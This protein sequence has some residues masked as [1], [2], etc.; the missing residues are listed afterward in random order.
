MLVVLCSVVAVVHGLT[1]N[2]P[3]V[4]WKENVYLHFAGEETEHREMRKLAQSSLAP[5]SVF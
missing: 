4:L 1:L 2:L 3:D 5:E